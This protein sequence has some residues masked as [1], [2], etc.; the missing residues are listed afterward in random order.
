MMKKFVDPKSKINTVNNFVYVFVCFSYPYLTDNIFHF[1]LIH[2]SSTWHSFSELYYQQHACG[3]C[4]RC[5]ANQATCK[6]LIFDNHNWTKNSTYTSNATTVATF[7]HPIFSLNIHFEPSN[8]KKKFPLFPIKVKIINNFL[9]FPLV[10][11][12]GRRSVVR[13]L[14]KEAKMPALDRTKV[15][16]LALHY[17]AARG[18]LECVKILVESSPELR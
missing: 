17:A 16:A 15:G 9:T 7:L 3:I 8:G 18:C 4:V 5:F 10:H 14:V 11:S 12:Y 1:L 6:W 2:I 13:W